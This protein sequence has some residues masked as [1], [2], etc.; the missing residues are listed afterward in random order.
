MLTSRV[1]LQASARRV[2]Q[3][4][5]SSPGAGTGT[6]TPS[7]FDLMIDLTIVDSNGARKKIKGLIGT[8]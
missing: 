7:V 8:C 2:A 5:F 3:R 6:A 1:L 4:F